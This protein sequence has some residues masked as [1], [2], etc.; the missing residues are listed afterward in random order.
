MDTDVVEAL[1]AVALLFWAAVLLAAAGAVVV[2]WYVLGWGFG[3]FWCAV[4][5][6]ALLAGVIGHM[7]MGE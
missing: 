3:L 4:V 7:E 1:F 6:V 2:V 5:V